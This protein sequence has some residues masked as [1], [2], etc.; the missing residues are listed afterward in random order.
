MKARTL[1]PIVW[2]TDE[3][4]RRSWIHAV[5]RARDAKRVPGMT[6][7]LPRTVAAQ[8]PVQPE[9]P[10]L[11]AESQWPSDLAARGRP[12]PY[13][14][15]S[16]ERA[17]H[18]GALRP[19]G[20]ATTTQCLTVA[21]QAPPQTGSSADASAPRLTGN[22]QPTLPGGTFL[23]NLG[24]LLV[25]A[26]VGSVTIEDLLSIARLPGALGVRQGFGQAFMELRVLAPGLPAGAQAQRI[27]VKPAQVLDRSTSE[28]RDFIPLR[29]G[30]SRRLLDQANV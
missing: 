29:E 16:P 11:A 6:H 22:P 18:G 1:T 2:R 10:A 28:R 24:S 27:T 14:L 12:P 30:P 8:P 7:G 15:P 19:W 9:V 5:T 26:S 21:G 20:S 17:P 4:W 23:G 13:C 3:S 25:S